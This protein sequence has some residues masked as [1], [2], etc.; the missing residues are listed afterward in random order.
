MMFTNYLQHVDCDP[1]SPDNHSRNFVNPVWNWFVFDA[2]YHTVHHDQPG[3]HWSR[4]RALHAVRA[5]RIDP[6]LNASTPLAFCATAYLFRPL[7]RAFGQPT[8]TLRRR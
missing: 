4:Y 7:A 1:A 8:F 3:Q 2:G 5:A 6:R